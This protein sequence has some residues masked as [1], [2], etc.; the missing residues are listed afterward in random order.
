MFLSF[1]TIRTSFLYFLLLIILIKR[2]IHKIGPMG[3]WGFNVQDIAL[4]KV[5]LCMK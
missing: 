2:V 3:F 1:Y 4:F 5:V